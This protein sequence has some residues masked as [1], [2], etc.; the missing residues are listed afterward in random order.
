VAYAASI[1]RLLETLHVRAPA[2]V[3]ALALEKRR[4]PHGLLSVGLK[5][6]C[7]GDE[8]LFRRLINALGGVWRVLDRNV[9][10][11]SQ[12]KFCLVLPPLGNA[13]AAILLLECI[14]QYTGCPLFNNRNI[15][16]QVCSPG[17]LSRRHAALH[18]I[19]FYLSSDTL[20]QYA[21][22]DFATTVSEDYYHRGKRIVIYDAGPYGDFDGAF[23]WWA[24]T[25]DGRLTIRPSL[26]FLSAR[27]DIMVGPGSQVDIHNINLLA[28]LLVHA[29]SVDNDG[30][31]SSLG[32]LF[33]S[34]LVSLLDRHLLA[35]LTEAP[36]IC[37][38][39]R[40][41][42][43]HNDDLFLSA[44]QELTAYAAAEATRLQQARE[45]SARLSSLQERDAPGIL[46]EMQ[47]LLATYRAI[48]T[49]ISE[50]EHG[51]AT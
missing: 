29:Q 51:E 19:G 1:E 18:A 10:K 31:W 45:M 47:E 33:A 42:N 2:K 6:H 15:Q 16:L 17:R 21:L 28:T 14:E 35:G 23:A 27:T 7:L 34:D 32:E 20:R 39:E 5:L 50:E 11:R 22:D 36:W 43:T 30:Y 9:Y 13:R 3:D 46:G 40:E 48:V 49:S 25:A 44:L 8:H 24:R 26:P 37:I 41:G 4:V 38:S 12:A